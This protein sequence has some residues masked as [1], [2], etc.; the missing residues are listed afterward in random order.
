M[1]TCERNRID[2]SAITHL[3]TTIY[4]SG[5]LLVKLSEGLGHLGSLVFVLLAVV[6][7]DESKMVL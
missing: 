5:W 4:C 3:G 1:A 2:L 7:M 6:C